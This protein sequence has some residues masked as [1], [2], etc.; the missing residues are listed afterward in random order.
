MIPFSDEVFFSFLAQ[1][2]AAIWP[3]QIVASFLA[4]TAIYLAL[5]PTRHS[6]RIIAVI[7][8]V[9]WLWT[10]AVYHLSFFARINFW[11]LGFGVLFLIQGLLMVWSGVVRNRLDP[12]QKPPRAAHFAGLA[13][14]AVSLVFYPLIS[15][16][17][18][19]AL[20]EIAWVGTSPTPTIILTIGLLC[21]CGAR[22]LLGL[23]I[24][25]FLLC[26]TGNLVAYLLPLPQDWLL[27][28]VALALILAFPAKRKA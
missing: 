26:L 21:L 22:R 10:G 16:V 17:F 18:G 23:S 1:Y 14:L 7:L 25:P 3:S 11:D 13:C 9:L 20:A 27:L 28:P 19:R 4:L 24:I 15:A 12:A 5:K 8:A 6:G 2:N